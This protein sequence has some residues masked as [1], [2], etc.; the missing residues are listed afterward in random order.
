M[1]R[2]IMDHRRRRYG[3]RPVAGSDPG[4]RTGYYHRRLMALETHLDFESIAPL[5][6]AGRE[7]ARILQVALR[8]AQLLRCAL[9]GLT[10]KAAAKIVGCSEGTVASTYRDP[11]FRKQ[12]YDKFNGVFSDIDAGFADRKLALHEKL[13][14]KAG[15]AF[16]LLSDLMDSEETPVH[17]RARIAQDFMDRN[18]DTTSSGVVRRSSEEMT[19]VLQEA[20]KAAEEVEKVVAIRRS[21]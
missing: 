20:A 8:R 1:S 7:D 18:P 21:A 14:R 12:V 2:S 16:D 19:Q 5:A 11:A 3:L 9:R 10:A 6:G 13:E 4:E 15:E 17:L